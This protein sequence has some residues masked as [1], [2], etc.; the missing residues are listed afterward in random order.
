MYARI[1]KECQVEHEEVV[2]KLR[3]KGCFQFVMDAED[4]DECRIS[5][6]HDEEEEE[7]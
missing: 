4:R 7:C 6:M 1:C 2:E 3:S 5:Y